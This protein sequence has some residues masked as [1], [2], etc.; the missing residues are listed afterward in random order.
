MISV[1]TEVSKWSPLI[2]KTYII[3][4]CQLRKNK[5][6]TRINGGSAK[7][8]TGGSE[9][10]FWV[11]IPLSLFFISSFLHLLTCVYIIWATSPLFYLRMNS[12]QFSLIYLYIY[13]FSGSSESWTRG[14]MLAVQVSYSLNHTSSPSFRLL[15]FQFPWLGE[16][17]VPL[18][19]DTGY[20]ESLECALALPWGGHCTHTTARWRQYILS[21][22]NILVI[23]NFFFK[24]NF[25]SSAF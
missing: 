18:H 19:P 25:N 23:M 1:C 7:P 24:L 2:Y 8:L 11:Q 15:E 14:F 22:I 16:M 6:N 10:Q 21:I 13:H 4:T 9:C 5:K 12:N 3:N 20:G 17:P